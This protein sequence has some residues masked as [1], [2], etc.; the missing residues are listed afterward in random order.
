MLASMGKSRV[1][2]RATGAPRRGVQMSEQAFGPETGPGDGFVEFVTAGVRVK[3]EYS[4]TSCGY[5]VVVCRVL[6]RCPMCGGTTWEASSWSPFR[7]A[8]AAPLQ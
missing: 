7:R 2:R 3:G 8:A 4:C 5:G 6:P 1:P